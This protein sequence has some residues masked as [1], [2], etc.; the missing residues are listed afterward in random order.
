V[1]EKR[2]HVHALFSSA[3]TGQGRQSDFFTDNSLFENPAR[4]RIVLFLL[5][6]VSVSHWREQAAV[7]LLHCRLFKLM[8]FG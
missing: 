2:D 4:V 8:V 1:K 5:G 3:V 6:C 7:S